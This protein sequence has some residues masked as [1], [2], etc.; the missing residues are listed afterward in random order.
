[1]FARLFQWSAA[2]V[3]GAVLAVPPAG[4]I[5]YEPNLDPPYSL[6]VLL[7]GGSYDAA[8][9][10]KVGGII[11]HE[12]DFTLSAT[13]VEP[14]TTAIILNPGGFANHGIKD[15]TLSWYKGSINPLNLIDTLVVTGPT[16]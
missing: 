12:Y 6:D 11:S 1:M 5:T 7:S 9:S 8:F 2:L 16:G 14:V 3:V 4:A 13:S 15:F 10:S